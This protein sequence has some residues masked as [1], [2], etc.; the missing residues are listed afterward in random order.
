LAKVAT[1]A[2]AFCNPEGR[3]YA[4]FNALTGLA[5]RFGCPPILSA[6]LVEM[7]CE[8]IP[9]GENG[10][11]KGVQ[12]FGTGHRFLQLL[13]KE[14]SIE[15]KI[16]WEPDADNGVQGVPWSDVENEGLILSPS[17]LDMKDHLKGN[18]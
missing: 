14:P 9:C 6:G 3:N 17:A 16:R 8:A 4:A 10:L 7:C 5:S 18:P 15:S 13:E 12:L 2:Q 11:Q 1:V